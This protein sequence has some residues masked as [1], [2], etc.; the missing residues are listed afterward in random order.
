MPLQTSRLNAFRLNNSRL[1]YLVVGRRHTRVYLWVNGAWSDYSHRARV[2]GATITQALNEVADTASI[3]FNGNVGQPLKGQQIMLQ[4]FNPYGDP[5][6]FAGH[7]LA[8]RTIYEGRAKNIAYD[9]DC[10]D[11]TWTLTFHKVTKRYTNQAAGTIIADLV[12]TFG[13]AG[14]PGA[15]IYPEVSA[16]ALDEITFTNEDLAQAISRVCERVGVYWFVRSDKVVVV[17]T[18]ASLVSAGTVTQNLNPKTKQYSK[19]ARH[20]D[21]SPVATAVLARGGGSTAGQDAI[22]GQ[23]SLPV[24]DPAWYAVGGG[25]VESGPQRFTYA[26]VQGS[27][28]GGS[29]MG[30][31]P[32]PAINTLFSWQAGG[33]TGSLTPGTYYCGISNVTS[34]GETLVSSRTMT[35]VAGQTAIVASC[36]AIPVDPTILGYRVYIAPVN[37]GPDQLRRYEVYN[38]SIGLYRTYQTS[39]P[40]Q[41]VQYTSVPAV[42]ASHP[43]APTASTAGTSTL[44]T[45]AGAT[46][47]TV[48]DCA[49]FPAGGGWVLAPTGQI[50]R[51][52]GRSAASGP[53]SLTGIPAS[54]IGSIT[55]PIR[56]G[57]LKLAPYLDG[58]PASGAD[59]IKFDIKT[60]DDVYICVD[61][62]DATAISNLQAWVGYGDGKRYEFL[63]DGR[64]GLTELQRRADAMLA[65]RKDPLVTVTF[66]TTDPAV[67]VGKTITFNTTEPLITGT[68]LIQRVQISDLPAEAHIRPID[69]RRVVEASSRRFTFDDLVQQLKLVGRIN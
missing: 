57:T 8:V 23:T 45:P 67:S 5:T 58:I 27:A 22:P 65:Y 66:E 4:Q 60:G 35:I 31:V 61:R 59:C 20:E 55:A 39:G 7:I 18:S 30:A 3:T 48:D 16:T 38:T 2:E 17:F 46:S 53:G 52:T 33:T 1:N 62:S 43:L 21:L 32:S 12:A 41:L 47:I 19:L 51:Y 37:V 50:L 44:T 34:A 11:Y 6:M 54:G 14:F 64:L 56:S 68:F 26:S 9:C 40:G 24:L 10:I 25:I 13:P 63:T 42:D 36:I 15:L 69:A 29:T 28:G 49:P